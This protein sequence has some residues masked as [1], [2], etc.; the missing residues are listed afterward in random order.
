MYNSEREKREQISWVNNYLLIINYF[1]NFELQFSLEAIFSPD[2][3]NV[4]MCKSMCT[5][6]N[7]KKV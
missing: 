6:E 7:N 1:R 3:L 2:L 4:C 5:L